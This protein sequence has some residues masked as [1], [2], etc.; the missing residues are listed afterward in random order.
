MDHE[1][2]FRD[3]NGNDGSTEGGNNSNENN[4]NNNNNNNNG[5]MNH[6]QQQNDTE[7]PA[8]EY[9]VAPAQVEMSSTATTS[10]VNSM[11]V[12]PTIN[13]SRAPNNTTT[14]TTST[15]TIMNNSIRPPPAAVASAS[16]A[17]AA[18]VA[19]VS[20]SVPTSITLNPNH[21]PNNGLSTAS[22]NH[23]SML[24]QLAHL[25]PVM[26]RAGSSISNNNR[27]DTSNQHNQ[28]Q[29]HHQHQQH[30]NNSM[31]VPQQG[32]VMHAEV[33]QQQ[34][35][36]ALNIN[37]AAPPNNNNNINNIFI[38]PE[39]PQNAPE[40]ATESEDLYHPCSPSGDGTASSGW[41]VVETSQGGAGGAAPSARS[42][43][44][45]ALLNGIMYV[46]G[47][48]DGTVRVNT[49]HAFSFAEKRWSPV[50]PS[51]NSAGPPSPRD[52]HV[53]VA[54]GNSF[55]IHGGFDGT[56]RTADLWAFDFS[57][58]TWREIVPLHGRPP[59]PRHSHAAVVYGGSM[60]V[61][62]GY[63]GS[64]KS[65]L[66]EYDFAESRWT[67]VP[68]AGRRP[69]ARYR[70][71]CV[72]FRNKMISYGGHDGTRH[73]SDAHIFDFDTKTWSNLVTEG[74]PPSEF[75]RVCVRARAFVFFF[76]RLP[77]G[78]FAGLRHMYHRSHH[79]FVDYCD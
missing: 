42:L 31:E 67:V 44:A 40:H 9:A 1:G 65:D 17:S 5:I 35:Q 3:E 28:Q 14:N 7:A 56:A 52:R 34:P 75:L 10:A 46:F 68:A 61:F 11:M 36:Q 26:G 79:L 51:S 63:D 2:N 19:V 24:R 58:M 62:G 25:P 78:S 77:A 66:N 71:T 57:S 48:Y 47:G 6:H 74:T 33:G 13:A 32:A 53:A 55:Y 21:P 27:D 23:Q 16:S 30:N 54:F 76:R 72:V 73:L 20:A 29:H 64:Y 60:Y 18:P 37:V 45:A 49:F 70:A 59:S 43:H 38:Q 69:R 12:S 50:L 4:S 39:P 15:T 8:M 41:S 22:H